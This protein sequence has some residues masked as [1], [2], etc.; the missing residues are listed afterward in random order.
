MSNEFP[1]THRETL[2]R[3]RAMLFMTSEDGAPIEAIDAA[4]KEIDR[5]TKI[6]AAWKKT[7]WYYTYGRATAL[8]QACANTECVPLAELNAAKAEIDRLTK[9]NKLLQEA[10]KKEQD[11]WIG[12]EAQ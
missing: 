4:I 8:V 1:E 2:K 5:L 9:E 6:E 7:W 10:L 12:E 3:L 11:K